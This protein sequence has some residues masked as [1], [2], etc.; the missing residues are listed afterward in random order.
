MDIVG[1][2]ALLAAIV[3]HLCWW[4]R[5][6]WGG[7]PRPGREAGRRTA[8]QVSLWAVWLAFVLFAVYSMAEFGDK[9]GWKWLLAIWSV[10][11]GA[12]AAAIVALA[13]HRWRMHRQNRHQSGKRAGSLP[14]GD[15][16]PAGTDTESAGGGQ[17]AAMRLRA[18][19]FEADPAD[20]FAGDTLD[21]QPHVE[22]ACRLMLAARTPATVLIDARW[23][24]GKTAFVRMAAAHIN[25]QAAAD[26]HLDH[27]ASDDNAASGG[28]ASRLAGLRP[29]ADLIIPGRRPRP[30]PPPTRGSVGLFRSRRNHPRVPPAHAGISRGTGARP[31]GTAGAPRP[32]GDQSTVEWWA[33]LFD[34]CPPPTRGS[35][36]GVPAGATVRGVPPAHAG[37]SR[38][39]FS[40]IRMLYCAPRPRGDQSAFTRRSLTE[41]SVPPPTR[42]SVAVGERYSSC[43]PPGAG[44]QGTPPHFVGVGQE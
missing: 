17:P 1:V 35:V 25:R 2:F 15:S 6:M 22:A 32:R 14:A 12:W 36:G 9:W 34:P 29:M 30:C 38:W 23:G 21:R 13:I 27:V 44:P 42:G 19:D 3:L 20:P 5:L 26:D 18:D 8:N 4:V 31:G 10:P 24:T 11:V 37:I 43:P 33:L 39:V 41:D 16:P 40:V 28:P 7:H